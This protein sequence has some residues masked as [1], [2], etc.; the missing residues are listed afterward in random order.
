VPGED[1]F[2]DRQADTEWVEAN[3]KIAIHFSEASR[4]ADSL[5]TVNEN[6]SEYESFW[7]I[8]QGPRGPG[9]QYQYVSYEQVETGELTKGGY[10]VFIMPHSWAIS[11]EEAREIRSF[12]QNGGTVIAD[13]VPGIL[14]GH[15]A[16]QA[17]GMLADLFPVPPAGP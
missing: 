11:R 5:V 4:I 2:R 13:V 15:G 7:P 1:T 9:L 12:V 6:S 17:R 3:D 16:I 14:D 10:A 8:S